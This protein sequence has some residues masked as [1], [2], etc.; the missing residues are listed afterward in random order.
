MAE[1]AKKKAA[2][3]EGKE[4]LAECSKRRLTLLLMKG[5]GLSQKKRIISVIIKRE[6][7]A[8]KRE[9]IKIGL[10]FFESF[11]KY[12]KRMRIKT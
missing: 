1:R 3:P 5:L 7:N 11:K 2:W 12:I 4:G 6:K 10:Y 8:A 9:L